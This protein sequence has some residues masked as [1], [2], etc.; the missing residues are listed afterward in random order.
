MKN[1]SRILYILYFFSLG[2]SQML[3]Q[4]KRID[5]L[6]SE[7]LQVETQYLDVK[8]ETWNEDYIQIDSD[9]TINDKDGK[10]RHTLKIDQSAS[11]VR[12]ESSI[13]TEGIEKMVILTDEEG[14]R[15]YIPAKNW[16]ND[17]KG[18]T[19]GSMN[20]GF[21]INGTVH[22][23]LPKK[24]KLDLSALYGDIYLEGSY[25]NLEAHS[26]Y[27]LVEAKLKDLNRMEKVDIKSVYDIV[28]LTLD[29]KSDAVLQMS[30]TYGSVFSDLPL[31][32]K[33]GD[34]AKHNSGCSNHY[35]KYILNDGNVLIDIVATYDNIY[36]RAL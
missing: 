13:D 10:D 33:G 16:D 25:L 30:T 11:M 28:D 12:I 1:L 2:T 36:V 31:K 5:N 20:I 17:L 8:L 27:G 9:V 15:T 4:S 35:E 18:N 34:S 6:R 3:A 24:M 19:I 26:T 23:R 29:K 22:I 21:E 32:S 14:N 7:R